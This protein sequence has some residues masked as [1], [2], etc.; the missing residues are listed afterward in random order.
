METVKYRLS[1]FLK[2]LGI[3]QAK[4]A[5]VTGLSRGYVNNVGD[6]IRTDNL[7]K[8]RDQFPELNTIWLLTGMGSMLN[9]DEQNASFRQVDL[10]QNIPLIPVHAHA[11][12]KS[13]FGDVEY[14]ETLPTV[15][16]IVDRNYRGKYRCFEIDGDSMDDGSRNS[17]CDKDVVLCRDVKRDLWCNKLHINDWNFILVTKEGILAKRIVAH[18]V[19]LG[20]VTCHSLNPIYEDFDIHLNDVYELY[21]IIKI[22][23]RNARI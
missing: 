8:I 11:G 3:G 19:E 10:F 21:N 12:Y 22:V 14:I 9:G 23:D 15:P 17:I 2:H 7:Q 18:N 20:I 4:F 6:S 16:V 1:L 5:E 13:G